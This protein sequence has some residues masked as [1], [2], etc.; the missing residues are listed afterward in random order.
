MFK[1][2]IALS[3]GEAMR[4]M[5]ENIPPHADSQILR[6]ID[7]FRRMNDVS[8][9]VMI[10]YERLAW[11]GKENAELRVT[12][13]DGIR[14]R[15]DRLDLGKGFDGESLLPKDMVLM[16]IKI[17]GS[18]PLWMSAALCELEIFGISFSK[19]G[20]CYQNYILNGGGEQN[21]AQQHSFA[22][23]RDFAFDNGVS[24]VQRGVSRAG[25]CRGA[26]AH[27]QEHC[28]ETIRL[29]S[30]WA[31]ARCAGGYHAS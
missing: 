4:Y 13:D 28:L 16:E 14:F 7:W 18:M 27:V 30:G 3:V 8:A 29:H 9:R 17:P 10:A 24:P 11:F 22:D 12:F 20:F 23:Q 25:D 31:S 21:H 1:R 19:Y 15:A 26:F 5:N 6:E 2:R